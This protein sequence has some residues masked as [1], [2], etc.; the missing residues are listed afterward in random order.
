M[1]VR[2]TQSE[3]E[4]ELITNK[5]HTILRKGKRKKPIERKTEIHEG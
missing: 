2:E 5:L 4:R 3:R 1:H